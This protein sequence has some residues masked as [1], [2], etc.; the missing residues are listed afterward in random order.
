[1]DGT[2]G[3]AVETREQ[4]PGVAM[5]ETESPAGEGTATVTTTAIREGMEERIVVDIAT[6]TETLGTAVRGILGEAEGTGTMTTTG[7]LLV[8]TAEAAATKIAA[9]IEK[10]AA[11]GEIMTEGAIDQVLRRHQILRF[12]RTQDR[13]S[14]PNQNPR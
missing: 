7:T 4:G 3:G 1:M 8:A 10:A 6:M 14:P 13:T 11:V 12:A 5:E 2:T 9:I